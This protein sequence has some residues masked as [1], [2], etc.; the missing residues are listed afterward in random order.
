MSDRSLRRGLAWALGAGLTIAAFVAIVALLS[1]DFSDTDANMVA[2]GLGFVV[3]AGL[4]VAGATARIDGGPW[5]RVFGTATMLAAGGAFACFCVALWVG[6]E[7]DDWWRY[8]GAAILVAAS[9]AHVSVMQAGRR[10]GDPDAIA[11]LVAAAAAASGAAAFLGIV[12]LFS[13]IGEQS[14]ALTRVVGVLMVVVILT[15]ALQPVARHAGERAHRRHDDESLERLVAAAL[16]AADRL[17]SGA[18]PIGEAQR[19]RA[20]ARRTRR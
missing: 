8:T 12:A 11:G 19:L 9:G 3:A 16:G 4:G 5:T 20:A 1:G 2:T 14:E 10:H 6:D 13:D 15:S 7:G 18:D 17:E